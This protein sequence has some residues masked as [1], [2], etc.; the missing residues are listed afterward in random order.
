MEEEDRDPLEED[1]EPLAEEEEQGLLVEDNPQWHN[2]WCHPHQTLRQWEVFHKYS[3]EI[4][5]KLMTSLKKSKDISISMPMLLDTT[6]CT[7]K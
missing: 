3:M 5:P 1:Q 6:R 7:R 4:D 2:N